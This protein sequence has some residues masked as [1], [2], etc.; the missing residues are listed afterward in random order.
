M[1]LLDVI[2]DKMFL[3]CSDVEVVK[4]IDTSLMYSVHDIDVLDDVVV[5]LIPY[6]EMVHEEIGINDV[7]EGVSPLDAMRPA[8]SISRWTRMCDAKCFPL[9]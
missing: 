8:D 3:N 1:R 5:H 4:K 9:M 2:D 7:G 6:D